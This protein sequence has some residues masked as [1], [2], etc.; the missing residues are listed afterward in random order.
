MMRLNSLKGSLEVQRRHF[1]TFVEGRDLYCTQEQIDLG[2]KEVLNKIRVALSQVPADKRE[3]FLSSNPEIMDKI[4]IVE[5]RDGEFSANQ[6]EI[7]ADEA[8]L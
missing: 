3:Q 2:L 7:R 8:A 4:A 1:R 5:G 6:E